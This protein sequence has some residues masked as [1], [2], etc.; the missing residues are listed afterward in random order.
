M[1]AGHIYGDT[2]D[3]QLQL[4]L[5]K[6]GKLKYQVENF[7]GLSSQQFNKLVRT[8]QTS[9]IKPLRQ[10]RGIFFLKEVST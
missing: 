2:L 6:D 9:L 1:G 7:R 4:R 3:R 5:H 8:S 10:G